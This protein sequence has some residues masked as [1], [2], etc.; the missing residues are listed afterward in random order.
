MNISIDAAT[1]AV[2]SSQAAPSQS[3]DASRPARPAP[4]AGRSSEPRQEAM[5]LHLRYTWARLMSAALPAAE[6]VMA[7]RAALLDAARAA[8][9][10]FSSARLT[11]LV[12]L[13]GQAMAPTLNAGLQP[14][15]TG[16]TLLVRSIT[17]PSE[18]CARARLFGSDAAAAADVAPRLTA[19]R[20]L[21]HGVSGRRCDAAPSVVADAGR[22]AGAARGCAARRRDGV[23]LAGRRA[24]CVRGRS[25][26]AREAA[27]VAPLC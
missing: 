10:R 1:L 25:R 26:C 4:H 3:R 5:A 20:R 9:E 14:K 11:S 13:G 18:R 17:A 12:R 27:R 23:G 7:G 15:A 16:E 21:Q 6:D 8:A 2:A 19:S 22:A 24:V